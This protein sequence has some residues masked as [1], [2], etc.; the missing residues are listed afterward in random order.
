MSCENSNTTLNKVPKMA[1]LLENMDD[2]ADVK[3]EPTGQ[4]SL[5]YLFVR[6]LVKN[7]IVFGL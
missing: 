1:E 3:C 2:S 5:K 4:F 6:T 7:I